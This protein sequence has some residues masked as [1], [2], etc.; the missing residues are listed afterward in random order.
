MFASA[1][2]V[3]TVEGCRPTLAMFPTIKYNF[4][5]FHGQ[6]YEGLQTLTG[7]KRRYFK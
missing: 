4:I 6:P 7:P 5:K 3:S 1:D 2:H